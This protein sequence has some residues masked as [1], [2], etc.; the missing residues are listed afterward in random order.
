MEL[1]CKNC[2]K[3]LTGRWKNFCCRKCGSLYYIRTHHKETDIERKLRIWL[4][5]KNI[6]FATQQTVENITVPDFLI[7]KIA[8]FADG[9]FWHDRPRRKYLDNRINIRLEKRGYKVLRYK[10]SDILKNFDSVANDICSN[11]LDLNV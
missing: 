3:K 11:I 4:E 8:L 1:K 6:K 10:G 7:G 9:E 5:S 2:D